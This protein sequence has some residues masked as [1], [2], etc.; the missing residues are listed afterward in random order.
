MASFIDARLLAGAALLLLAACVTPEPQSTTATDEPAAAVATADGE[1][2]TTTAAAE[3]VDQDRVICK[4]LIITGSRFKQKVCHTWKE[5]QE[6]EEA[7]RANADEIQRRSRGQF[8][9]SG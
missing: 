5:W 2:P 1:A 6:I 9:P 3:E 8:T 7:A 4:R